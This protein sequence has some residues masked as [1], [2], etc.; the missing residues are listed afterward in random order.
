MKAFTTI[1]FSDLS[2]LA[3]ATFSTPRTQ[4]NF[5]KKLFFC[6][7]K[8]ERRSQGCTDLVLEKQGLSNS[9]A[10][11]TINKSELFIDHLASRL[12]S[13]H[14]ARYLVGR[15]LTTLE[16][17]D[18]LISYLDTLYEEYGDILIDVV[19]N[20]PNPPIKGKPLE[21]LPNPS[22]E[23]R[24]VVP[25][26]APNTA[27][28][29]KK[30]KALA[31]VTNVS[32][33][34]LP[35]HIIYLIELG[36]ELELIKEVT[37]KFPAFAYYSLE[38]KVKPIVE[39]L[40]DLGVSK[41][42]IPTILTKRPQLCGI[43]LSENLIPTMTFLE[44]LGVDK[45]Q[46]AKVIYR[47]PALLTY[48]RQKLMS[49][50]DFLYEMGLSAESVGKIL[51][52]CP[53]IIS[54]S[55]EDKLRP[56]TEYFRS[57]G[58]DVALLLHR[59]PQTFGLSIEANL[60]PV[61]EFFLERGYN[62]EDVATMISRYGALYTFSL[63]DNLIPKWE[64]F[65]TMDYPKSELIKFPQYFVTAWKRG[66]NLDKIL[67]DEVPVV[68]YRVLGHL[69][70]GVVRIYSKK[71]EYLFHD[72]RK[73][74]V[75]V[76]DFV[77]SKI[78][79]VHIQAMCPPYLSITRPKRFEL[80]AFDLQILEDGSG[81]LYNN[82]HFKS[83]KVNERPDEDIMLADARQND[84]AGHDSFDKV[85]MQKEKFATKYHSEEDA[86]N[87]ETYSTS[88]T[89]VKDVLSHYIMKND[90]MVASALHN[91][92]K[93]SI[94][95]LRG[96]IFSLEECLDPMPLGECEEEP[97]IVRPLGEKYPID[98]QQIKFP[99]T[100]TV[101]A[102]EKP[103][104]PIRSFDQEQHMN[105]EQIKIPEMISPESGKCRINTEDHLEPITVDVTFQSKYPNASGATTPEFMVVPTPAAKEQ[106]RVS[107]KRRCL[108]DDIIVLP[109]KVLKE[110]ID[111]SSD[112]I[113][114]RR[115]VPHTS[116][117][118]WKAYQI[119][120][121]PHTFSE[122]LI[123]CEIPTVH[124][125]LDETEIVAPSTPVTRSTPPLRLQVVLEITKL[126]RVGPS[127]SF[128]SIEKESSEDKEFD[129]SLL[130]EVSGRSEPGR[131]LARYLH[132]SILHRKKQREDGVVNLS[133][134]LKRKTKGE[135]AR[136]FYEILV[137]KTKGCIDTKQNA[138]YD[139]ILLKIR[140]N[141]LKQLYF[142]CQSVL[143]RLASQISTVIQGKDKP[144]YAPNRDGG[145]MCIVLNAK[146]ICVKGRKLTDKFYRW[147][148]GYIGHLKE[149]SLKDQLAKDPTEVIRKAVLRM[150]PR[151]KLHDGS[152]IATSFPDRDRK[153]RI[154]AGNE[155][156]FGD[157]PIEPY[158]MPPRQV[159]EMRPRARRAMIRAQKK[160]ELQKQGGADT[161]KGKKK[162]ED[163]SEINA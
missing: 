113:C 75:K 149:R 66:L 68:T 47:F 131:R 87:F 119:S 117:H 112:L 1:P 123:P 101:R 136:V 33:G 138:A 110:S 41:S 2:S 18:A 93:A 143:G 56:T 28:N 111:D 89:P 54:Y 153:L 135:S 155:H 69:L 45:K 100:V 148:T 142:S 39:F 35:P 120:N 90:M 74:L 160:A 32:P 116:L 72:C 20:F 16:I 82:H 31:R 95:K 46:W 34:K 26:S 154:F 84:G 145:D 61:T 108:F 55:V 99:A 22:I 36:M 79:N 42:D 71:V 144:T 127:R 161:R 91:L 17:R 163:T 43:S 122:S 51:T 25:V 129:F 21:K 24:S 44:D 11:R 6:Q 58:V 115:K 81:E 156:P 158:V 152:A 77:G 78:T 121:L 9:V 23:H 96:N 157:R 64:F 102:E 105:A 130:N 118:A 15:E 85:D 27:F 5:P 103:P 7:A 13:V 40:L 141:I 38:G 19:E 109:N 50:V 107:R 150:L 83:L 37:R 80:D 57:L 53:H 70:L 147:H 98:T 59:S 106:A 67:V 126:D 86:A 140:I 65:L 137:L 133:Q 52:R 92:S 73:V 49:T 97:G 4:L 63:L 139:D 3:R 151:N 125:S 128:E 60:K 88:Y 159:R 132:R 12:H 10:A 104:D 14:K 94:E 114:K 76:N 8:F 48:S 30:L 146:D 134:V 29:S 62:I 124:R 162:E